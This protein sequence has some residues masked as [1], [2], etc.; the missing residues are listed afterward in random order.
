MIA[1][2]I[3]ASSDSR[4]G[5]N[6]AS[7]R[8]PPEQMLSTV[9]PVADDDQRAHLRLQ[10][11]VDALAQRRAGR[12]EPQRAVEGFRSGLAPTAPPGRMLP[13]GY[14]TNCPRVPSDGVSSR[15]RPVSRRSAAARARAATSSTR[16]SSI[17]ARRAST[18]GTIARRKPSRCASASRRA[19]LRHLAHLAAE[20]DLADDDRVGADRAVVGARRRSR[21]RP[22]GRRRVRRPARRPATLAYTS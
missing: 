22:R 5:V 7:S 15:S 17:P 10:D 19:D 4:C 1:P 14:P 21:A 13:R 6:S 18:R 20:A 11:A 9:G 8:N 12:D 2:S 3:F 16:T